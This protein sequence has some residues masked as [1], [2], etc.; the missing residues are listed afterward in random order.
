MCPDGTKCRQGSPDA[1]DATS[2]G[3]WVQDAQDAQDAASRLG[4]SGRNTPVSDAG[5]LFA[6]G[7]NKL[8]RLINPDTLRGVF[9]LIY[10][11][12][13]RGAQEGAPTDCAEG[14]ISRCFTI[15]A[16]WIADHMENVTLHGIQSNACP[17]CEVPAE[18]LGSRASH[19]RA[20]DYARYERYECENPSRDSETH[21]A[22]H[23]HYTN[24]TH[25][26]QRGQNV[27]QGLVRVSTP[28]LHKPDMLHTLYLGLF[29]HMMDWIQGFLKKTCATAG[30][31]QCLDSFAP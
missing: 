15:M 3:A 8:Q 2:W 24:E 31:R 26:I 9:E 14:K 1:P 12:L 7:P 28:D 10:V 29:K 21:D 6:D 4:E 5:H 30:L 27:F 20:R 16:G 22:A 23:A 13:N 17:K 25:G 18:E 11:P 19:H